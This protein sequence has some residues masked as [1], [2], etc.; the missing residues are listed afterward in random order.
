M[1]VHLYDD[2]VSYCDNNYVC[3]SQ[4]Y[5]WLVR[6]FDSREAGISCD[7][8]LEMYKW[9]LDAAGGNEVTCLAQKYASADISPRVVTGHPMERPSVHG[10]QHGFGHGGR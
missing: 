9:M 8:F 2:R 1:S 6:S 7:G 4:V 5:Q 3:L 10:L